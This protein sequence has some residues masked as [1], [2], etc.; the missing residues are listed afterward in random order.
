MD[1]VGETCDS[2]ADLMAVTLLWAMRSLY[3]A[4]R[5]I[6]GLAAYAGADDVRP[7]A[8]NRSGQAMHL[9]ANP[10]IAAVG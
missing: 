10:A 2:D 6:S 5:A 4:S 8:A 1:E 9:L 7:T 3:F